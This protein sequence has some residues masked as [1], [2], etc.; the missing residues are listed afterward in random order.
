MLENQIWSG[1]IMDQHLHLE[2]GNRF[3][4]AVSDFTRSGGTAMM[5]VH[6]PKFTGKLPV[7]LDGYR[8]AYSDTIE[9]ANDVRDR[10][11]IDV[12]VILGPHPVSWEKQIEELGITRSSELHIEAVGLALELIEAGE[13]NCLGEV[14]RPHY[15]VSSET[16]DYANEILT[17]VMSMTSSTE[18]SLQLH[19]EENGSKTNEELK[20]ICVKSGLSEER[21]IRHFAPANVSGGFTSG[22]SATVNVGTGSIGG[23]VASIDD[24]VSPWGME[25]DYLDDPIRP[26]AV[27]GPKTVPKRTQELCSA[28]LSNGWEEENVEELMFN[29]HEDWPSK[30]YLF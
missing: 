4:E 16:W 11:E 25:T 24:A 29:I 6:K 20:S 22:L 15:P 12:G 18:S 3:L 14:G 10:F 1:P 28:L 8:S 26:G 9:M 30:L 5:L 13:A 19:V 7:D 27:L 2:R 23:L 21:A 17:E